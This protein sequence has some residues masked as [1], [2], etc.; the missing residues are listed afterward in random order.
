MSLSIMLKSVFHKLLSMDVGCENEV[1]ILHTLFWIINEIAERH[2]IDVVYCF[3]RNEEIWDTEFGMIVY[4]LLN[5]FE[6]LHNDRSIDT[7]TVFDDEAWWIIFKRHYWVTFCR[8][9]CVDLVADVLINK[10]F[11]HAKVLWRVDPF[12]EGWIVDEREVLAV[13]ERH[14]CC[15]HIKC[16][17]NVYELGVEGWGW[18]F[19]SSRGLNTGRVV[20]R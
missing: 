13:N 15:A 11:D 3:R 5:I 9:E 16:V 7:V 20:W 19:G 6:V 2:K 4:G 10:G 12:V 8:Y 18:I 14:C 17:K 1:L